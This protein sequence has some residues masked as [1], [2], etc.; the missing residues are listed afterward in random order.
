[1]VFMKVIFGNLPVYKN[2]GLIY[3]KPIH[4]ANAGLWCSILWCI[5]KS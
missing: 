2:S 3:A 5:I 1:M 4:H